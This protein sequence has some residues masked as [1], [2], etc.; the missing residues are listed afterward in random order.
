MSHLKISSQK[1]Q[2]NSKFNPIIELIWP[3]IQPRGSILITS[4]QNCRKL[5]SIWELIFTNLPSH[6]QKA[7]PN[8]TNQPKL[9]QKKNSIRCNSGGLVSHFVSFAQGEFS[10]LAL[11]TDQAQNGRTLL[12]VGTQFWRNPAAAAAGH[13]QNHLSA[14]AC[15]WVWVCERCS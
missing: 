14:F 1:A 15:V 7:T 4:N 13:L 10:K 5:V 3:P 2:Q 8:P 12:K 9:H 11:L 6:T